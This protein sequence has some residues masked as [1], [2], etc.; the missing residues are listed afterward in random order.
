MRKSFQVGAPGCAALR[1]ECKMDGEADVYLNGVHVARVIE[2][3]RAYVD[4]DVSPAALRALR[5]GANVLAAKVVSQGRGA[6][7]DVGLVAITR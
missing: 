3:T 4:F 5:K 7:A 1:L 6:S 2:R